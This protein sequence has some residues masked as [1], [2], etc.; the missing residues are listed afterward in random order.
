MV[1]CGRND[2]ALLMSITAVLTASD[3]SVSSANINTGV[4]VSAE[5]DSVGPAG[6]PHLRRSC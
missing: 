2:T 6:S 4:D 3:I 1:L 5:R